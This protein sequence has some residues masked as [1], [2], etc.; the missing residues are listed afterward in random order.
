MAALVIALAG[1]TATALT[2]FNAKSTK[3][4]L[5]ALVQVVRPSIAHAL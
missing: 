5:P 3:E 4:D 2:P 1:I